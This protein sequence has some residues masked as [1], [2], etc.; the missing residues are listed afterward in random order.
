MKQRVLIAAR[1]RAKTKETK[2]KYKIEPSLDAPGFHSVTV[3]TLTNND[4]TH[5]AVE[6]FARALLIAGH[7]E[8][9]IASAMLELGEL[10][11]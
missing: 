7:N 9:N 11:Q 4:S 1:F 8:K 3:D 6:Q 2:M 10:W 5:E